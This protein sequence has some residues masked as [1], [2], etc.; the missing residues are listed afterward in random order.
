MAIHNIEDAQRGIY[1]AGVGDLLR[2]SLE[3]DGRTIDVSLTLVE[4][5]RE[6]EK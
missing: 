4:A 1:G 3:R 5:P 2:L 6:E